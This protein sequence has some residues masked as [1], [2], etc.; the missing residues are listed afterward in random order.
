M[1]SRLGTCATQATN[2]DFLSARWRKMVRRLPWAILAL[3]LLIIA[4][5][6]RHALAD[7]ASCA[8][9]RAKIVAMDGTSRQLP[10][11]LQLRAQLAALYSKL[12]S[13]PSPA[14]ADEFWYSIDGKRLGPAAN[15][16]PDNAA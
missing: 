11:Y 13:S 6:S 9:F 12:C 5:P 3:A 1:P 15:G 8:D 2:D 10:G 14:S 4:L 16:R 7:D